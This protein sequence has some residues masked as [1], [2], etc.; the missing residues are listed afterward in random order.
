MSDTISYK[1]TWKGVLPIFLLALENGTEEGKKIAIEELHKMAEVADV[2]AELNKALESIKDIV[3]RESPRTTN[4]CEI[5]KIAA[6]V[7]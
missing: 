2:A 4:S 5:L 1:M 6:K 3:V 7:V